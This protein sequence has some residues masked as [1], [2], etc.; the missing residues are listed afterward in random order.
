[1]HKIQFEPCVSLDVL[2]AYSVAKSLSWPV[3]LILQL[4]LNLGEWKV[5]EV[6]KVE[7]EASAKYVLDWCC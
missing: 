6:T 2:D 7:G 5:R 1:M 4:F 3:L